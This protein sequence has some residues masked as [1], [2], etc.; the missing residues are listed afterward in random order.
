MRGIFRA[1]S[2][3]TKPLAVAG[4]VQPEVLSPY[5]AAADADAG[6][7]GGA[8]GVEKGATIVGAPPRGRDLSPASA[9]TV[10]SHKTRCTYVPCIYDPRRRRPRTPHI[11]DRAPLPIHP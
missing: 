8:K 6:R 3:G 10:L 4:A 1:L 9:L 5:I 2:R 11:A 7:A